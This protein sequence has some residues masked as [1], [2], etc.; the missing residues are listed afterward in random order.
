M[1][2]LLARGVS[3]LDVEA[4]VF[5]LDRLKK[6]LMAN[7]GANI[8]SFT[9]V[10]DYTVE[11]K[12]PKPYAVLPNDLAAVLILSEKYAKEVGDEQLDL[13]PVG[14]GPYKLEKYDEDTRDEYLR[15]PEQK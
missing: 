14:T 10:D 15:S 3:H 13:K 11:I 5:T 2:A 6:S 4:H 9:A 8:A 12:T 1:S 7:L